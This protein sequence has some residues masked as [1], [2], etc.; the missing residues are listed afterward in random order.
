MSFEN[1]LS[2]VTFLN[3]VHFQMGTENLLLGNK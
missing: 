1:E 2:V 3:E